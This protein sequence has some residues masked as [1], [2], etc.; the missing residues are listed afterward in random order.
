M[1]SLLRGQ[2]RHVILEPAMV[3]GH[4][5]GGDRPAL[6]LSVDRF[7]ATS[8]LVIVA[9]IGSS[10]ANNGRIHSF[11]IKSVP[12][13]KTSWVLTDQIRTLSE[14]RVGECYGTMSDGELLAVTQCIF[15]LI[16]APARSN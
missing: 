7:N 6:I 4:E 2:I 13:P 1:A 9:L 8:N 3:R 15:G 5:Q 10:E 16:Y 12:M 11:Q 14:K